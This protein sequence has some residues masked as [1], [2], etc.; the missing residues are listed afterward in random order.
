[1]ESN[2]VW[3]GKPYPLGATFDGYGTNFAV[4]SEVAEQI[5]LCIFKQSEERRVPLFRGVGSIWHAYLPEL[6]PGTEY[7]FRVHGPWEPTRG[8]R[9][10]AHKLLI[11][12]YARELAGNA[13]WH[14]SMLG[15]EN[16]PEGPASRVDSGPHTPKSVV[17]SNFFDW[18]NDRRLD[19]PWNES[20][21]YE[22]H[23]K[24]FTMRHPDIP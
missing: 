22:A 2:A 18:G 4:F 20:I 19:I 10:N 17:T 9:C 3:F 24:G 12:P 15:H 23:V 21:I 8:V 1:M 16:D 14:P 11:D 6:G 5:E 13:V 7:G